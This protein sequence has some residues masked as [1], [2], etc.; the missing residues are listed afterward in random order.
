MCHV[1]VSLCLWSTK[2]SELFMKSDTTDSHI[3]KAPDEAFKLST[4]VYHLIL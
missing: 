1:A 4:W 2:Q 3:L